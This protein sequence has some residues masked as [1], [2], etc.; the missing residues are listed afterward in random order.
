M[1]H[2]H[3]VWTSAGGCVVTYLPEQSQLLSETLAVGCVTC[4][5]RR[6]EVD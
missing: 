6:P 5:M 3:D 1:V 4:L 2:L